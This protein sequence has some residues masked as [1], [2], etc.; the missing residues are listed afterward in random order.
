[1]GEEVAML[2]INDIFPPL[3]SG[4]RRAINENRSHGHKG[5]CIAL[6]TGFSH[7]KWLWV[8]CN[9]RSCCRFLPMEQSVYAKEIDSREKQLKPVFE[10]RPFF[11]WSPCLQRH[12]LRRFAC[13]KAVGGCGVVPPHISAS[14][15]VIYL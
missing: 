2:Q 7:Y 9:V 12:L 5:S 4:R 11:W 13:S 10:P 15:L 8:R 14:V 6:K 3:S 1:M